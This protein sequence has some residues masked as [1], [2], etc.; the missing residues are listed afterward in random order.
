MD[1]LCIS[2]VVE[3]VGYFG[4]EDG[5]DGMYDVL[6]DSCMYQIDIDFF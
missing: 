6:D 3:C 4:W 2:Y 5:L 1:L